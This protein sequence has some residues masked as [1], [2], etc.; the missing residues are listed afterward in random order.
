M[1]FT[2]VLVEALT[3]EQK[4]ILYTSYDYHMISHDV[5]NYTG[6]KEHALH[7]RGGGHPLTPWLPRSPAASSRGTSPCHRDYAKK[8]VHLLECMTIVT[9]L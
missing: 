3:N 5:V 1:S 4:L 6:Y 8:G 9:E 7:K 2:S